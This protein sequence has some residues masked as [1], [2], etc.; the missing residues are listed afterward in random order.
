VVGAYWNAVSQFLKTGDV[1]LLARFEGKAVAGHVLETDPDV[2]E[3][4]AL[5]GG[6]QFEDIYALAG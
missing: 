5:S 3:E 6:L 4:L 2:L 1:R